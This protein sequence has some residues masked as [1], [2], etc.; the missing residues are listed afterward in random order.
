M[1]VCAWGGR[2]DLELSRHVQRALQAR[3]HGYLPQGRASSPR[4]QV[5]W[6]GPAEI[7]LV[8]LALQSCQLCAIL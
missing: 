5:T 8:R 1:A 7:N 6:Q 2:Y 3:W 4:S